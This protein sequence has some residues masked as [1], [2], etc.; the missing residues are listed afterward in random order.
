[1]KNL[2]V[3]DGVHWDI[4]KI[5]PYQRNFNFING[6]RSL[7]KTY[8][9]QMFV[10]DKCLQKGLEFVYI[11]R[12]QDEKKRGALEDGFKKVTSRVFASIEFGYSTEEMYM[13][14]EGEEKN[15]YITLGYCIALSEATKI[16]KK[17][18]PNVKYI[19][20]D[21]Y[22]LEDNNTS[23]YVNGWKEPDLLLSIYHTIDREEDRVICFLLG[24]NTRFH[25]P[26]H[27]HKAFSIPPVEK[28]EIW[29]SENVLFQYA[30]GSPDLKTKKSK[31]KFLK[32]LEGTQYGSY[33]NE[34]NYIYDNY[35]FISPMTGNTNYVFTMDYDGKSF[36][37]YTAN[38]DGLIYI[39]D[40]IDPS[41]PI[42]YALT[43]NDHTENT[44]LTKSKNI[45]CLNWLSRNYKLGNVRFI[46][47]EV[48][49]QSEP[50]ILM[51][52]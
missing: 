6:E 13:V 51:I 29:M 18:Y 2:N 25:N 3:Y 23:K 37:V 8:T 50:G 52:V 15:D 34:G 36:G 26:Y 33:A 5:L 10:L 9:T 38:R 41:C 30:I 32:M 22:M 43:K 20:F 44:M 46:S 1:M 14:I 16:K 27:M 11:V 47:M 21:E 42:A 17:S 49:L 35:S 48:K 31:S 40:K 28:G 24:N 19:I 39:S 45:A 12:T 4:Y 7:G